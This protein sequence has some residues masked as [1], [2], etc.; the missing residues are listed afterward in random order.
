MLSKTLIKELSRLSSVSELNEVISFSRSVVEGKTKAALSVGQKV[1]VVQKTK[2]TLGT[3]TKI[4]IKKAVVELPQ[5]S[6]RVPL[7][8]LEA[9]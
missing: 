1:Y 8:M 4:A 7:S 6:Y 5:G 9:A 2:K 3:I